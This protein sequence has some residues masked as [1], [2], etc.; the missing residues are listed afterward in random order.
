MNQKRQ[1][2]GRQSVSAELDG[3]HRQLRDSN[4]GLSLTDDSAAS[5]GIVARWRSGGPADAAAKNG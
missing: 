2:M 3:R 5:F 4:F 1:K